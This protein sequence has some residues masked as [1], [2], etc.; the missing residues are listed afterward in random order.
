MSR[1]IEN[2]GAAKLHRRTHASLAKAL[3]RDDLVVLFDPDET[4][5]RRDM[6]EHA[7][8]ETIADAARVLG[9]VRAAYL[10]GR[11]ISEIS[12]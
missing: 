7:I 8:V 5:I 12:R 6:A 1:T 11:A 2:T 4:T 9:P 3:G 10:A